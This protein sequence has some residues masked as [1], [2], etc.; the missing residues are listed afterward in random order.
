MEAIMKNKQQLARRAVQIFP[1]R[2]YADR[3]AVIHQRK[4]WVRS[5][6]KLG[7]KW[8]LS[9]DRDDAVVITCILCGFVL[10]FL[11]V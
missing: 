11:P 3:R 2:D 7:K 5:M 6:M 10:C 4:G 9:A 1:M 8:I